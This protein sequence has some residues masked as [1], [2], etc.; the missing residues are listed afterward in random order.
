MGR[1]AGFV[2]ALVE[3]KTIAKRVIA[4]LRHGLEMDSKQNQKTKKHPAIGGVLKMNAVKKLAIVLSL[5]AL[6]GI[7]SAATTEKA[8]VASYAG[9]SD[10]PVP[11][12]IVAPE[13]AASRGAEVVLKFVVDK[14]G[15]P[16]GIEVASSNNGELAD[17]AVEA[18]KQWRFSPLLKNGE[19]ID[20]KVKLP[21]RVAIP[22]VERGRFAVNY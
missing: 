11:V 18:V 2:S 9:V 5:G 8:Y 21:F 20:A 6:G 12:K 17:A 7:A 14:T 3:T 19:P 4:T 15:V 13:I 22:R 10:V 1:P 16:Q